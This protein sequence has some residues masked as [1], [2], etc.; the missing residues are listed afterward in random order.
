MPDN[1]RQ[2]A[3]V[4]T[5][6]CDESLSRKEFLTK[7]VQK[8]AL[9]G[10]LVAAPKIIDKF[11]VPPALA[12]NSTQHF[13]DSHAPLRNPATG[14]TTGPAGKTVPSNTQK[15]APQAPEDNG[16]WG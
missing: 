16:G 1:L 7:L 11:L 4:N 2:E 6:A 14:G 12:V 13:H 15:Q 5:T 3:D 9:A 10:S 8:A